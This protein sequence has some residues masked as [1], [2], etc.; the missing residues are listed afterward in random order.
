MTVKPLDTDQLCAQAIKAGQNVGD[1]FLSA[2]TV[3][4][5]AITNG[6]PIVKVGTPVFTEQLAASMDK[7]GP[8][9]SDFVTTVSA[10]IDAMHAD[11]TL[12]A[13]SMKWFKADLTIKPAG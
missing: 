11:G 4:D 9:D 13:M 3:I 8:N 12:T 7:S 2:S 6:T 1:G 10:I 5:S